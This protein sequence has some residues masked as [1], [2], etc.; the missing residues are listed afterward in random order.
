MWRNTPAEQCK[1]NDAFMLR[2]FFGFDPNS[3][4]RYLQGNNLILAQPVFNQ[5][6]VQFGN[7]V[8]W[9]SLSTD[10]ERIIDANFNLKPPKTRAIKYIKSDDSYFKSFHHA[11]AIA[12]GTHYYI[13]MKTESE[14]ESNLVTAT[15]VDV[16]V[17]PVSMDTPFGAFR[18]ASYPEKTMKLAVIKVHAP[19]LSVS[20]LSFTNKERDRY[21]NRAFSAANTSYT[22]FNIPDIT[23]SYD[24]APTDNRLDENFLSTEALFTMNQVQIAIETYLETS[25]SSINYADI[26]QVLLYVEN[27]SVG[28][29]GKAQ[30]LGKPNKFVFVSSGAH[31]VGAEPKENFLNSITHEVGHLLNLSHPFHQFTGMVIGSDPANIMD[32]SNGNLF[33]KYQ[34][35][36]I[37]S[38]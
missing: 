12:N 15:E 26:D 3:V 38:Y 14:L 25:K 13:H 21:W 27:L 20:P 16:A 7:P 34:W 10:V 6:E 18:V 5:Y 37:N 36:I 8:P 23:I 24:T 35:D 11:Q 28:T 17:P 32:Y 9:V 4:T 29:Y 2:H 19:G 31:F 1:D 33:R 30:G 22:F